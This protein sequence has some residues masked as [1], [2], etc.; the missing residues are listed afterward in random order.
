MCGQRLPPDSTSRNTKVALVHG[1]AVC[2]AKKDGGVSIHGRPFDSFDSS[3]QR[4][5]FSSSGRLAIPFAIFLA[6]SFVISLAAER[7]PGSDSK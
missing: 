1:P 7:R 4:G 3:D 2:S 5:A 6:S